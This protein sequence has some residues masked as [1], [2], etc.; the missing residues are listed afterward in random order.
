[1]LN[2]KINILTLMI[3]VCY[4][5]I[6]TADGLGEIHDNVE[7]QPGFQRKVYPVAFQGVKMS[8]LR[9]IVDDGSDPPVVVTVY[10]TRSTGETHEGDLRP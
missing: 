2:V 7:E 9:S 3:K 8:V 1:M 10:K 6:I 4:D 5:H